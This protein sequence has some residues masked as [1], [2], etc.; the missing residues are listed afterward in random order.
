MSQYRRDTDME[1][2]VSQQYG[3]LAG[4]S[5]AMKREIGQIVINHALCD[6]P[7][8]NLFMALSGTSEQT[9]YILFR[10]LNLK[11]GGMTKAILDLAKKREPAINAELLLRLSNHIDEY[12]KLSLLRNEVAHWQW[13]PS[14]PG[15]ESASASNVM[16][17][18]SDNKQVI[19]EFTL[20]GLT[21]LSVGLIT[22]FSALSL[23][24][25]LIQYEIPAFGLKHVFS[26]MDEVSARVKEALLS[27]PEPWAEELP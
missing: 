23:F 4:P 27:L 12:R 21:E 10:S 18:S 2:D 19:K 5:D 20:H 25:G 16:R 22:T 3:Y 1:V 13:Q 8:L 11:A 7:L 17:R 15:S 6:A 24:A 14:E 9:A 26:K